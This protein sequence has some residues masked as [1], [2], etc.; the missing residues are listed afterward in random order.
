MNVL[1]YRDQGF[2]PDALLNHL[3]RLGWAHGDQEVFG[4]DE[5]IRLFDLAQVNA[6]AA[7]FDV[8][9]LTWLNQQHIRDG[10]RAAA[11]AAL[12]WQFADLGI[13][14]QAGPDAAKVV[15]A[16]CE[17]SVNLREMAQSCAWLYRDALERDAAAAR[18]HLTPA[19]VPALEDLLSRL[20]RCPQWQREALHVA[21]ADAASAAGIGFGKLGQPLRVALCGGT[22]SPPIDVTL[23][24]V[25]R[26][27]SV[28]RLVQAIALAR[29]ES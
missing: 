14:E 24:L 3:V 11:I 9:K 7:R 25:G 27:R 12:R 21:V 19:I 13:D 18:K 17:R 10:D 6:S 26:E 28:E 20:R 23:V 16:W 5:M 15:D 8:A 2:L 29:G 1:E 4:R 22:V